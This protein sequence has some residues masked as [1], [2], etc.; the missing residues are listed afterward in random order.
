M[1]GSIARTY[2][3]YTVGW[4]CALFTE[5]AAARA[6]LDEYY[7]S[8]QQNSQDDNN[9]ILDRIGG[10]NIMSIYLPA[11]ITGTIFAAKIA[12]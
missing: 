9:Y 1:D 12:I 8:L 11:G 6:I 7:N 10:H 4:I 2:Q 3:D 5:M